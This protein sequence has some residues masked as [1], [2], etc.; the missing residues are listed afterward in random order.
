MEPF[1]YFIPSEEHNGHKG[2]FQEKGQDSFHR[3]RSAKDIPNEP[4]VIRP[5]GAKFEFQ[6]DTGSNPD[7]EIDPEQFHPE[8]RD[9][10]PLFVSG[11]DINGRHKGHYE[12]Q[13]EG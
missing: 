4:G 6:N 10:F 5:V 8:F 2:R 11:P 7:G 1:T 3:Q 9:P 12:G 13:S